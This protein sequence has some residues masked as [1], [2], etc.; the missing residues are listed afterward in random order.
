MTIFE[1]QYLEATKGMS[2]FEVA[3]YNKKITHQQQR[4]S[5]ISTL[6]AAM[7]SEAYDFMSDSNVDA[8]DR[9]KGICPM[10]DEYIEKVNAKRTK[11]GVSELGKNGNEID[12]SSMQYCSQITENL[13]HEEI[14]QLIESNN[15]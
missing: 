14:Q 15:G 7:F 12:N 6:H 13:S 9:K 2:E 11:L 3:S 5:L 1:K 10:N 8:K 4:N